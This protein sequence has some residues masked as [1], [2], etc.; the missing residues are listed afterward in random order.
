MNNKSGCI[1]CPMKLIRVP[2]KAGT[3]ISFVVNKVQAKP[4][5]TVLTF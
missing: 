2:A 5:M 1:K 3:L 4:G